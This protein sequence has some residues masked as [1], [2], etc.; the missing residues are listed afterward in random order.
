[1]A[2]AAG[3]GLVLA[4]CGGEADQNGE[5]DP[6]EGTE[7]ADGTEEAGGSEDAEPEQDAT[8]DEDRLHV[9]ATTSILGDMIDNL[10]DDEAEVTVL[11]PPGTDP[12]GYEPS[13]DDGRV[14]READLVV[15]NGLDLEENLISVL[16]AAEEEGVEVFEVADQLDPIDFDWDGP[17]HD[18]GHDDDDG[19]GHDDDDGHG[20]DDDDGHG[21]DDDDGHGHDDD[22]G[23]GHDDDD[24]DHDHDGG[25]PHFWLD[26]LR[27]AEGVELI[28]ERIAE[29]SAAIDADELEQRATSYG[30]ELRELDETMAA[31]FETV[32]EDDR[33]L[34]TNHDALGYLA[35][36]YGFEVLDTVIPGATTQAEQDPS[37]FAELIET[38]EEADVPAIFAENTDSTT[39]A[40]QLQSE[41]VGRGDVDVEVVRIYT[42]A[43]GEEGSGAETYL[44]LLDTTSTLI[45]EAL[46]GEA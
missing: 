15:A 39:L 27:S 1:M 43:L 18:H 33:Q 32:P 16:E 45:T 38:V 3:L 40:E 11:M 6:A 21:H 46:G 12:H 35:D 19:H 36:R 24:H 29:A 8:S 28:A 9:V 2:L 10:V 14:L 26:P 41:V 25:D 20:H 37:G 4:A 44:G 5:A 13:A 31:R 17:G 34:V 30:D 22:D 23:H 7:E 42:D